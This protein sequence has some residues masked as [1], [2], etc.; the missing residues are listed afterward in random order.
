ML[1]ACNFHYIREDFSARHPSIFGVTP[2]DFEKQLK[3]LANSGDF[4]HPHHFI[5]DIEHCLSDKSNYYLITFDDGLK[6][7]FDYAMPILDSL[8]IPAVFFAN[9]I[10]REEGKVSTVH[11]IHL[12]RSVLSP[13]EL[14]KMLNAGSAPIL[15][16]SEKQKAAEIYRYDD[17]DSAAVKYL[18]NF[19]MDF[20]EQET[21]IKPI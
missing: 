4:I 10:N 3:L 14:A 16:D 18:L 19:K 7:Q 17:A 9:S 13:A 21:L 15:S 1:T 2:K 20:T 11:K 6:E 12:L 8:N 5:S